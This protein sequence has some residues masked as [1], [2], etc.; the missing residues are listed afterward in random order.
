[1][2]HAPGSLKGPNARLYGRI[3]KSDAAFRAEC[4]AEEEF[5]S[6]HAVEAAETQTFETIE[7][8]QAWLKQRSLQRGF[9]VELETPDAETAMFR[10][11][12]FKAGAARQPRP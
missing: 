7:E 6:H 9:D 10:F 12:G 3:V 11:S 2:K 5:F 4:W 1:M 8:A